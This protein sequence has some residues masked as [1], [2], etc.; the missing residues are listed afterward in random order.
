LEIEMSFT[1]WFGLTGKRALVTGASRGLGR[2]MA[3]ALA[4]AGA[5]VII[6]GRTQATL[7]ATAEEIRAHGRQA[8]TIKANMA[9]PEECQSACE[10]ILSELGPIDILVNNVGNRDVNISIE[11]ETLETWRS[12]I[13]LNLTSC[14][15][16]TKIVGAAMLA[17]G[18]GGRIINIASISA[19]IANRGI[20]GRGYETGKAALLHFTHCAAADWAPHGI[21]VNA[22]CPG[23]FMTDV[24]R[25]WNEKRPDV[26]E[27][28]VKN[29]PMGRPGKPHEIGPLAVYLA[30][31]SAAYVTGASYVIDGGYTLW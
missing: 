21:T 23:L 9:V 30:S 31:P 6:T 25:E 5:D 28:F 10:R 29:V 15:L 1:E 7:D 24:N 12:V 4:E 26:I 3:L 19:L 17:R 27:T 8:W 20:G 22:I 13:D 16:A 14:F 11:E 18:N 2:E